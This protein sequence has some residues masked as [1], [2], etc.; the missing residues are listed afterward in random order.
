MFYRNS[1]NIKKQLPYKVSV[2]IKNYDH[3]N[4]LVNY[5]KKNVSTIDRLTPKYTEDIFNNE[6]K[7]VT[8][9]FRYEEDALAFKL[10]C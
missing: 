7:K 9:L 3:F 6:V 2:K 4:F 5:I 8:F 10:I 1:K